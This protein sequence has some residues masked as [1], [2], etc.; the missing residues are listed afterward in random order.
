MTLSM[1]SNGTDNALNIGSK[2]S[3]VWYGC[4]TDTIN[5]P[6]GV[7]YGAVRVIN[8][9][10]SSSEYLNTC[11]EF[12]SFT[13]PFD[14][15]YNH[16]LLDYG[17][18]GWKKVSTYTGTS[19]PSNQISSLNNR[20]NSLSSTVSS[21]TNSISTLTTNATDIIRGRAFDFSVRIPSGNSNHSFDTPAFDGESQSNPDYV[22]IALK[23]C[24]L[25]YSTTQSNVYVQG[26]AL[27]VEYTNQIWVN[28]Y[29]TGAPVTG[30]LNIIAIYCK[31]TAL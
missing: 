7:E 8:Y 22:I 23:T 16:Y 9:N 18:F 25:D 10:V 17:W 15:Y 5:K 29:N 21:H 13:S 24:S 14:H 6:D 31:R 3:G 2:K 19:D 11:V 20:L 30:T 27:G 26:W 1:S 4:N 28:Y 12:I